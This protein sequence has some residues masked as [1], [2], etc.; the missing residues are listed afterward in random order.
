MDRLSALSRGMQLM[1]VGGVLLLIDSFLHWQEVSAKLGGVTIVS[2]GVSAWHGFWGVFMGLALIVLL[3]WIVAKIAG[4][5]I[6]LPV[7]ETMVAASLSAIILLFALI[8]NLADDYSTK[9]SYIGIV[10]AAIVAAGAWLE[11]QAAGG[12]DTLKTEMSSMTSSDST[13]SPPEPPSGSGETTT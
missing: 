5:K 10:L 2:A 6:R 1:L 8:K 11:V 12:V 13:G 7:S 9:W 4:T 3:A